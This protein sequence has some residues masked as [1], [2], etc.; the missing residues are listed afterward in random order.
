[1][2]HSFMEARPRIKVELTLADRVVEAISVA[3]LALLWIGILVCY[4]GLPRTIPTHFNATLQADD[5]GNKQTLFMLPVIATILYC[6]LSILNHYPHIF[7]YPQAVTQGN[8]KALYTTATRLIRILK[9]A[10]IIIF[11]SIV[12]LTIKTAFAGR[13][14]VA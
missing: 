12:W 8:A 14:A 9:L 5:F 13:V 11:S 2:Q 4:N 1:M 7:N 6:S 10:V 3:L